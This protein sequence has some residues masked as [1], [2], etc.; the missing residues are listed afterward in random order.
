MR[1]VV[2]EASLV[3]LTAYAADGP[4]PVAVVSRAR[5]L[6]R[7]RP[8]E[9]DAVVEAIDAAG[10]RSVVLARPHSADPGGTCL[11]P[12]ARLLGVPVVRLPAEPGPAAWVLA[13]SA[14]AHLGDEALVRN[15]EA[16][17][18][19]I[20]CAGLPRRSTGDGA[21]VPALRPGVLARWA[22]CVWRPCERCGGG[23]PP[24]GACG[25]CGAPR[26]GAA[27]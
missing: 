7:W 9:P 15:L 23:G 19:A 22:G 4:R 8:L 2:A 18:G 13:V 20:G 25:R 16:L 6:G 3:A 27:S 11:A 26:L 14:T 10:G 17:A 5:R 21:A 24:G 1:P 12:V